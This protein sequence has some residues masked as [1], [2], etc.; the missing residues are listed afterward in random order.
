M[1]AHYL[2][3]QNTCAKVDANVYS[4]VP[5]NAFDRSSSVKY[6]VPPP[7]MR[8]AVGRGYLL[9]TTQAFRRNLSPFVSGGLSLPSYL[10]VV[11][12]PVE[13]SRDSL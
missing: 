10:M 11:N 9:H 2:A 4:L 7:R 1:A 6:V 5:G 13:P 3:E 8:G 12:E